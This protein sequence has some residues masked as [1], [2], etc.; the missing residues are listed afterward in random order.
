MMNEQMSMDMLSV[1]ETPIQWK[2]SGCGYS[3]IVTMT[4]LDI[5]YLYGSLFS[6]SVSIEQCGIIQFRLMLMILLF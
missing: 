2:V 1:S 5:H 4:I 3:W 6:Q